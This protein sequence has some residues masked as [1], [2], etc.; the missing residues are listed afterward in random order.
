MT[1]QPTFWDGIILSGENLSFFFFVWNPT[2]LGT[3]TAVVT[4]MHSLKTQLCQATAPHSS[5][6]SKRSHL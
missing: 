1:R 4:E 6:T 3:R 5:L 2:V